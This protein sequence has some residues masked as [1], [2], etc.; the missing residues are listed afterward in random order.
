MPSHELGSARNRLR[1]LSTGSV[2]RA[3]AELPPQLGLLE[4]NFLGSARNPNCLP[5]LAFLRLEAGMACS[6]P[7]LLEIYQCLMG[8]WPNPSHHWTTLKPTGPLLHIL[9]DIVVRKYHDPGRS[10]EPFFASC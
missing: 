3:A 8:I 2:Q 7:S 5:D 4:L 9:E 10:V 6:I 1:T